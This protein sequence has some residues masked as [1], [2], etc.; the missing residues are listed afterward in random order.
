MEKSLTK[1][2]NQIIND[3]I[4]REFNDNIIKYI[5]KICFESNVDPTEMRE[6]FDN[7][8]KM[9][10][11]QYKNIDPSELRKELENGIHHVEE[12]LQKRLPFDNKTKIM[13]AESLSKNSQ[14]NLVGVYPTLETGV[15]FFVL[16]FAKNIDKKSNFVFCPYSIVW[17]L[18]LIQCGLDD[19]TDFNKAETG[20][21]RMASRAFNGQLDLLLLKKLHN[22]LGFYDCNME[23]NMEPRKIIPKSKPKSANLKSVNAPD[24][25]FIYSTYNLLNLVK[26][27]DDEDDEDE[28]YEDNLSETKSKK[29]LPI[30][31]NQLKMLNIVFI[32]ENIKSS[33]SLSFIDQISDSCKIIFFNDSNKSE[34]VEQVNSYVSQ[35]RNT[36]TKILEIKDIDRDIIFA[37]VLDF[38]GK[39]K[40]PFDVGT[41]TSSFH[42]LRANCK[43]T[44][45]FMRCTEKYHYFTDVCRSVEI[46]ELEYQSIPFK[47]G[48]IL[49]QKI[50]LDE[51]YDY[52]GKD[53]TFVHTKVVLNMPKISSSFKQNIAQC[54]QKS[55]IQSIFEKEFINYAG[56]TMLFDKILHYAFIDVDQLGTKAGAVTCSF[57]AMG[58]D[59]N[60]IVF[61]ANKSFVYYIKSNEGLILFVG[62]YNGN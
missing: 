6:Y 51:C 38:Y 44:A 21:G 1:N 48:V 24:K 52:V 62:E 34:L 46:I 41:K 12:K 20:N 40:H 15:N 61:D 17:I 39:W 42:N 28:K 57:Q 14:P 2:K 27:E 58:V 7:K 29:N 25:D 30:I 54:L 49:P 23:E 3:E 11:N 47:F 26:E 35:M 37:N 53:L 10:N 32:N 9:S 8:M 43:S 36:P 5:D 59:F 13:I 19:K 60:K 16:N 4:L 22:K 18:A 50:S 33:L 31:K 55:G 45:E 56:T